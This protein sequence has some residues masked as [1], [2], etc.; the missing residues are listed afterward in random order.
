M[1]QAQEATTAEREGAES[2]GGL[3]GSAS[4]TDP[5]LPPLG[6]SASVRSTPRGS[7][8]IVGRCINSAGQPQPVEL[9]PSAV[10]RAVL[11]VGSHVVDLGSGSIPFGTR[12]PPVRAHE[13][14]AAVANP[15]PGVMESGGPSTGARAHGQGSGSPTGPTDGTDES[16]SA[17]AGST[18]CS[19]VSGLTSG[20]PYP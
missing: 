20:S 5:R 1:S 3:A 17:A 18:R 10:V 15:L 2:T 12:R 13:A 7:L 19:R 4:E 8:R 9:P 6:A 16:I 14:L 11:I